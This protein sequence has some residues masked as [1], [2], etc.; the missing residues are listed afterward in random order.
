MT[1]QVLNPGLLTL[2]QDFGRYRMQKYGITNSGPMD[3]HAFLWANKLLGNH[4]NASQLEICMGGFAAR[5]EQNT[6]IAVCG[7][8]GKITLND[9]EINPW[10]TYAVLAGDE[11]R[12]DFFSTGLYSYLAVKGGFDV[13]PQLHSTA[14]VMRELLGGANHDG[15]KLFVKERFSYQESSHDFKSVIP[16][17]YKPIS[18]D[19][20]CLRFVPNYSE[21]G[22][23]S[24]AISDFTQRS[25]TV[26]NEINRMGYRLKGDAIF[27]DRQGIIS[28]GISVGT[29]QLPKDGQPIVLMKD[30]QTIGGYPQL[31][32]VAYLDL[33][34]LSQSKPGTQVR[35]QAADI[36]ELEE[37]LKSYL[38]FFQITYAHRV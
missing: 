12:I 37:D 30:R 11:V 17:E 13:E 5:F 1:M 4:F 25:F 14:T 7:A 35:F 29:I 19:E 9:Q 34:M 21:T 23:S 22:C 24:E 32:C 10:E 3:E 28:Q 38:D 36:V 6:V 33:A 2:V 18:N 15:K 27:N 26:S 8:Q 20:V 31:G 16:S